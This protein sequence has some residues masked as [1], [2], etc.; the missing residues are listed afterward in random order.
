MS[1]S[2]SGA[3][4]RLAS[5]SSLALSLPEKSNAESAAA[6]DARTVRRRP[7]LGV[8]SPSAAAADTVLER[9]GPPAG[10]AVRGCRPLSCCLSRKRSSASGGSSSSISG[11]SAGCASSCGLGARAT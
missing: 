5:V 11:A 6:A 3:S 8:N 9:R 7:A 2:S 10:L 4:L 1:S